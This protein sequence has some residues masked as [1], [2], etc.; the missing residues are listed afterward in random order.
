MK[1]SDCVP[2]NQEVEFNCICSC[3]DQKFAVCGEKII[4]YELKSNNSIST[5]Q[6]LKKKQN[7]R[8]LSF[9][10]DT[11]LIGIIP[12]LKILGVIFCIS[13]S[14]LFGYFALCKFDVIDTSNQLKGSIRITEFFF[15]IVFHIFFYILRC[16]VIMS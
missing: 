16:I 1:L 11:Q 15:L 3:K 10:K 9:T 6:I 12:K 5:Y 4:L 2:E 13:L 8:R 14:D 7:D